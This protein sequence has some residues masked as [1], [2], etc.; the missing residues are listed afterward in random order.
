MRRTC[1][2]WAYHPHYGRTEKEEIKKILYLTKLYIY[3]YHDRYC[4]ENHEKIEYH[5]AKRKRKR[6]RKAEKQVALLN[7]LYQISLF[8]NT[9][10]GFEFVK[11]GIIW[12]STTSQC[13]QSERRKILIIV[14]NIILNFLRYIYIY[15]NKGS[16]RR[17]SINKCTDFH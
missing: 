17:E 12:H 4:R 13:V 2:R 9:L 3:I 7:S 8:S 1:E 11:N 15:F 10:L 5:P 6:K 14:I 16:K